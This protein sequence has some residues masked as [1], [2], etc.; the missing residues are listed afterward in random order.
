MK[1]NPNL[2]IVGSPKC[3]TTSLVDSLGM[4]STIFIPM[5]KEP[6]HFLSKRSS[7]LALCIS[8]REKYLKLYKNAFNYR[9]R[10]DASTSY[11]IDH[12]SPLKIKEFNPDAK[13]IILIRDPIERAFSHFKM[14]KNT[15][16][17]EKNSINY[18]LDKSYITEYF[19]MLVNPYLE[20]SYYFKHIKV[21]HKVFG[22][23]L[24]VGTLEDRN[25]N[26]KISDFL[27]IKNFNFQKKNMAKE[28]KFKFLS[29]ITRNLVVDRLRLIIGKKSKSILKSIIYKRSKSSSEYIN[30]KN[31]R[32][33]F[34]ILYNDNSVL[35]K[36]FNVNTNLWR[37]RKE[38]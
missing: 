13:I 25:L 29:R 22:D 14:E 6:N 18:C 1:T 30:Q 20:N 24:F 5:I 9:Y 10:I 19:G 15:Y 4:L 7:S 2:F 23:Q 3:G 17:R 33:L 28:F 16:R 12:N 32:N 37:K 27:Q 36:E 11:F 38:K 21:W 8:K 34:S 26:K 35:E 31:M